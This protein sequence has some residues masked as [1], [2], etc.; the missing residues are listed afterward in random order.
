MAEPTDESTEEVRDENVDDAASQKEAGDT[1][2]IEQRLDEA[3]E[4]LEQAAGAE[5]ST[6]A[7]PEPDKWRVFLDPAGHPFCLVKVPPED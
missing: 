6:E 7:Q 1:A 5:V 4:S 3:T 2:D